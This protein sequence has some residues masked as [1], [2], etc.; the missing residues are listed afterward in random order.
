ML[1]HAYL[2][3][4]TVVSELRTA[5][6]DPGIVPRSPGPPLRSKLTV[7]CGYESTIET[8]QQQSENAL[9]HQLSW[10]HTQVQ[11]LHNM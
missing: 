5:F 9:P 2:V 8:E 4:G 11:V 6:A 3:I 10:F 7:C 1:P